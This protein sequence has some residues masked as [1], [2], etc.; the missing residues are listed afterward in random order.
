MSVDHL[1]SEIEEKATKQ[2]TNWV[3]MKTHATHFP[4][5]ICFGKG[6]KVVFI[7]FKRPGEELRPG[8][9]VIQQKLK[10]LGFAV[11]TCTSAKQALKILAEEYEKE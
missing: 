8:Q 6:G 7:E 3:W 4:D 11:Y 2:G 1:E 10:A 9:Q 5:R